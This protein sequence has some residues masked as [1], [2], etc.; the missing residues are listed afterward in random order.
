MLSS[1]LT[2]AAS[3]AQPCSRGLAGGGSRA[4]GLGG[5]CVGGAPPSGR[6]QVFFEK[7]DP[8]LLH[9]GSG[10]G[11]VVVDRQL[12]LEAEFEGVERRGPSLCLAQ[13]QHV[14]TM[15]WFNRREWSKD[16]FY[17]WRTQEQ[18]RSAVPAAAAAAAVPE[19]SAAREAAARSLAERRQTEA[20]AAAAARDPFAA[21][22]GEMPPTAAVAPRAQGCSSADPFASWRPQQATAAASAAAVRQQAAPPSRAAPRT[23]PRP[24]SAAVPG[25][26][27]GGGDAEAAPLGASSAAPPA[28]TAAAAALSAA[29]TT[30]SA[31][32]AYLATLVPERL[33]TIAGLPPPTS[34]PLSGAAEKSRG[35]KE[36]KLLGSMWC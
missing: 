24:S 10:E 2:P 36:N 35:K 6:L 31:G 4:T 34:P 8:N 18:P 28:S 15:D 1:P 7:G 21:W 3:A 11:R 22:R 26:D 17:G 20:A 29:A 12:E 30:A 9:A 13:D 33:G 5:G 16:P 27:P 23:R 19:A 32:A 25:G 14:S